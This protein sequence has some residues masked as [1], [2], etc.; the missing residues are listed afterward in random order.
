MAAIGWIYL[1]SSK[2]QDGGIYV[3]QTI[4]GRDR[5]RKH[6]QRLVGG[7]HQNKH[8]QN[9]F[10]KWGQDDFEFLLAEEC[11]IEVLTQREQAW[12]DALNLGGIKLY[13]HVPA[14]RPPIPVRGSKR[15][16][17]VPV[18]VQ[19][20]V[21]ISEKMRGNKNAYGAVR[22]PEQREAARQR[23]LGNKYSRGSPRGNNLQKPK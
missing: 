7:K 9:A 18:S 23:M 4:V 19:T 1:I 6:L 5:W 10:N 21:S 2:R 13:N 11:S 17:K 14:G 3:G 20:R 8:L 16:W 12:M 22:T 15:K